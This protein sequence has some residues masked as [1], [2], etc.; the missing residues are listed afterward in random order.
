MFN[1]FREWFR[2]C[3]SVRVQIG[4]LP[5]S[6]RP[7]KTS[8]RLAWGRVQLVV[9]N[10]TGCGHE[11]RALC[12]AGPSRRAVRLISSV[13]LTSECA[14]TCKCSHPW[15]Q[16]SCTAPLKKWILLI[17]EFLALLKQ[18]RARVFNFIRWSLKLPKKGPEWKTLVGMANLLWPSWRASFWETHANWSC[19][20]TK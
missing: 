15:T 9:A 20:L 18:K 2:L 12:S 3:P 6:S 7:K 16:A 1:Q 5:L 4:N 14:V 10:Q 19:I 13:G 11:V 17:V 8:M